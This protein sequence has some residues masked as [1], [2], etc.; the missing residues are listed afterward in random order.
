MDGEYGNGT[1]RPQ[2]EDGGR[3]IGGETGFIDTRLV[4]EG[5]E[6]GEDGKPI[7]IVL[8]FK[9]LSEI[10][11]LE[12]CASTLRSLDLSS[13]NIRKI[14]GLK[15]MTKLK[16]LKLYGCQIARIQNLGDCTS[17]A[18]LHLDDNQISAVEGLDSL[19]FL[20]FL[21]LDKNKIRSLG[22]GLGRLSKLKELRLSS[23][24]LT[25]LS[26]LHG[27]N[28]LET[29]S[30]NS[31]RL[32]DVV[33]DHFKGLAKLDELTL[34][35][36]RLTSLRFL[37]PCTAGQSGL[38]SLATLDV[39]GNMLTSQAFRG[40]PSLPHLLDFN[41]A[42]NQI[43]TI[44]QVLEGCCAMIEILDLSG[45]RLENIDC[46]QILR[47]LP[48]LRELSLQGNP[49][50]NSESEDVGR[51]LASLGSLDYLDERPYV[52]PQLDPEPEIADDGETFRLTGPALRPGSA[53]YPNGASRPAVAW[54]SR[55]ASGS[56]RPTSGG[57]TPVQRPGTGARPGSVNGFSDAGI[58]D[59]L[60]YARLQ[61]T[62][63]RFASEEQVVQWERNTMN[64]FSSIE[65]KVNKAIDRANT[66]LE[67]MAQ[68]L[69]DAERV[70]ARERQLQEELSR[71]AAGSVLAHGGGRPGAKPHEKGLVVG[72]QSCVRDVANAPPR[73]HSPSV[74]QDANSSRASLRTSPRRVHY[75]E[76]DPGA[77]PVQEVRSSSPAI[78]AMLGRSTPPN[79]RATGTG[80]GS[81]HF[82]CPPACDEVSEEE[83]ATGPRCPSPADRFLYAAEEVDEEIEVIPSARAAPSQRRSTSLGHPPSPAQ[84]PPQ[85]SAKAGRGDSRGPSS[86]FEAARIVRRRSNSI[87]SRLPP[88]PR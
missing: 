80:S 73:S 3:W 24:V 42:N 7:A 43:E 26:G 62:D 68:Y 18:S 4:R 16:E 64:T 46:I 30:A 58:K 78:S 21:S 49:L 86:R 2:F 52:R 55:P 36:N 10:S 34:A 22:A 27:L 9:F 33:P 71:K 82:A 11:G 84:T 74:F 20:E 72:P 79:L 47:K 81:R 44:P 14:Q 12:T 87:G 6:G 31:N 13:N 83:G 45:N 50:A 35:C 57:T 85:V 25:S 28:A 66:G 23:N 19:K 56:S 40:L 29:L 60:M 54:G 8:Q 38:T 53:G 70:I 69:R 37:G 63:K 39:S 41:L 59:P 61:V 75:R 77:A 17:L 76:R 51:A 67:G 15:G 48:C 1:S 5:S 32:T 65:Q 88:K